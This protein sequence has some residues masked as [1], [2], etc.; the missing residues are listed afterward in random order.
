MSVV[1]KES[2]NRKLEEIKS[3]ILSSS[4]QGLRTSVDIIESLLRELHHDCSSTGDY[5]STQH[6]KLIDFKMV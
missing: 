4:H 5:I 3:D 1:Q 6:Y 2:F